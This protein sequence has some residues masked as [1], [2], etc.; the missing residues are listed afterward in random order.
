[1]TTNNLFVLDTNVLVSAVLIQ[2]SVSQKALEKAVESGK[3]LQ[4]LD[5]LN[6]LKEVLERKKFD[7]YISREERLRFF[8]AFAREA[9]LIEVT[10]QINECRDARDDKFLD[11]AVSGEANYIISG[12]EDL[13]VMTPFRGIQILTP[14]MFLDLS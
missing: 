13:L 4:S 1:M 14:K 8:T 5:T 9:T 7:K 6:E 11:V 3:I 12:D 10:T 2:G